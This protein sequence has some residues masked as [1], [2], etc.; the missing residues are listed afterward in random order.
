MY[1]K[2]ILWAEKYDRR[3]KNFVKNVEPEKAR[4]FKNF[5]EKVAFTTKKSLSLVKMLSPKT[6]C[7]R[8]NLLAGA[9]EKRRGIAKI[10]G[11]SEKPDL[12]P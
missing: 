6:T 9:M 8:K 12:S 5:L 1:S 7:Q 11:I 2:S 4:I 10:Q 3:A